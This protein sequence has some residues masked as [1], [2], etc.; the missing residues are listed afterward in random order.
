MIFLDL[1]ILNGAIQIIIL[2]A[3]NHFS[4][5][6]KFGGGLGEVILTNILRLFLCFNLVVK[7]SV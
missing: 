2:L 3:S 4:S 1:E 7:G 6:S 5:F